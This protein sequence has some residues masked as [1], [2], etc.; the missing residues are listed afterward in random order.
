MINYSVEQ[1]QTDQ[2]WQTTFKWLFSSIK[3]AACLCQ[4]WVWKKSLQLETP[5]VYTHTHTFICSSDMQHLVFFLFFFV[6]HQTELLFFLV[7]TSVTKTTHHQLYWSNKH[8]CFSNLLVTSCKED[9]GASRNQTH[10]STSK[11]EI[12]WI[13]WL[14][15]RVWRC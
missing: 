13:Y 5:H 9:G 6:I 14:R 7:S 11:V 15:A 8:V 1:R 10:Q 3:Q 12:E 4:L 2:K